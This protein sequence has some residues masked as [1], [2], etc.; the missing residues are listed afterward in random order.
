MLDLNDD[1]IV[2]LA[3]PIGTSAISVIR[4]SG[5][6][7]ISIVENIFIPVKQGKKLKN[8]STHT[9]HLGYLVEEDKDLLDQVLISIF[10]SPFSYTGENMIEIS[11]HGSYYIQQKILQLLIRKGTRL[12]R[13]GEFTFRAFLN[14]KI[15]LSQAEA[16]AD[17]ILSENKVHHGI[18]LQ[19]IKGKLSDNI[20]NLSKELLNFVSLLELEL[21]FSEDNLMFSNRKELILFLKKLGN[22]LKD[23]IESFSLGNAIK[24]GINVVIVGESNVGKSTFFNQV[25]QEDR[26]IISHMKGTTR[27]CIEGEIVLNGILFHFFDTA[28][29]R[30]TLNPIEVI[31][32]KKAIKKMKESQVILYIFDSSKKKKNKKIV[33]DIK[34]IK[35]KYPL[36]DL[37]VIANKSDLSCCLHNFDKIKSKTD[38]LFEISAKNQKEVKKIL[39]TLSKLFFDRLK[40]KKII[41]T[42]NRH[43]ESLKL[44]LKEVLL[45]YDALKK[46][47]S[48]DLVSIHIREALRYLGEITG[49]ITNEDILK[50]I[51]SKFCIGK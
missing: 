6:N 1:T 48:E 42:Q 36:K 41:I 13:P 5:K 30:N 28:G 44:S 34:N 31:G 46:E 21:D 18:S 2:A 11:C 26:S 27:D 51:F 9:I 50:N 7:S 23:L 47:L 40:K 17:L 43:Y 16:I 35:K 10:K 29:M 37:F 38:F 39:D 32:I 33:N 25:I 14:N 49:E 24:K 12:A 20:K 19:Q 22:T 45:A 8:Q 15:D 3:T 4:I